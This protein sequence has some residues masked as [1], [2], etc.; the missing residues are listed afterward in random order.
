MN[1]KQKSNITLPVERWD[2][3]DWLGENKD[4]WNHPK[5]TDRNDKESYEVADLMA[6]FANSIISNIQQKSTELK[7]ENDNKDKSKPVIISVC[8][9]DRCGSLCGYCEHIEKCKLHQLFGKPEQL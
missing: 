7:K 4:I 3:E 2:A 5:I 8:G 9:A 1:K 6:E